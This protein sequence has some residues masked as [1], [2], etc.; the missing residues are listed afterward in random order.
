MT[1]TAK[2][3]AAN[4]KNALKGGR[5]VATKTLLAQKMREMLAK[6]LHERYGSIIDSQL[7][8]AQGILIQKTKG[9]QT[10]YADPGPDVQA[11]RNIN[12]QVMGRATER[13]EMSGLDGQP[14][15]IKLDV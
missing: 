9:G 2:S 8:A 1:S 6:K 10:I 15:I 13:V 11:F 14:L 5:P 12:D 7:D 4:R 3:I